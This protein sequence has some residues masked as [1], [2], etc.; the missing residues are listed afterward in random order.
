MKRLETHFLI[1]ENV[2]TKIII[3]FTHFITFIGIHFIPIY[4]HLVY[5]FITFIGTHLTFL[6]TCIHP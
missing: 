5:P 1:E 3:F 4:T 2:S 6:C